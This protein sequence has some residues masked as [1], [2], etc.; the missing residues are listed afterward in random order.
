M[1]N[2]TILDLILKPATEINLFYAPIE[3]SIHI[4]FSGEPDI[5]FC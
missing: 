5:E 3:I 2:Q 1:Q 4:L